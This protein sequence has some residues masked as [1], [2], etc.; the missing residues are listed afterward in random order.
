MSGF[1]VLGAVSQARLR[2]KLSCQGV[3]R[4]KVILV[5]VA[6]DPNCASGATGNTQADMKPWPH[7]GEKASRARFSFYVVY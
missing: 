5:S 3:G 6:G 7:Q 2:A 4:K 1:E